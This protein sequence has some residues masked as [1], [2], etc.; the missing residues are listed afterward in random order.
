MELM[1][2]IREI[3]KATS[4]KRIRVIEEP[5]ES[6]PG[7]ADFT[8]RPVFSVFDY[9][10]IVPPIELDNSSVCLMAGYNFELLNENGIENHYLGL[11]T[12][13]GEL[14]TAKEAV[15]RKIAPVT[16]RLQFVNRL[17][18]EFADGEWSYQMFENPPK[19]NY[20]LPMEFISRNS[21]PE[22]SSIWGRIKEGSLTLKELG[23]PSD[24][25]P[26]YEVPGE[27]KPILDYSTK[28][29]PEDRYLNLEEAQEVL[30]I[31]QGRFSE[32]N[33]KTRDASNLMTDYAQSLEFKREDG[34]VE[35]ITL[36]VD[37]FPIDKLGD[38]VCSW[39]ED[40]ISWNGLGISKQRI[41]D[42]VKS[43]N[44]EWYADIQ[45]CKKRAREE[46]HASFKD[47]LDKSIEYNSPSEKFFT[48]TNR[49]FRTATN[50][51]VNEKVYDVYPQRNES[52][53]DSLERAVEEFE[54]INRK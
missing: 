34:K 24:F 32:I 27:L 29:E 25:K 9:G 19:N 6:S 54:G 44:E 39:H 35:Y 1:K 53:T 13:E 45:E 42:K 7:L 16:M 37:G 41:R 33:R 11:V 31:D 20:V 46:G 14:I 4:V 22:N 40:R 21:L 48:A 50:K 3:K 28:F 51:W 26:G 47:L 10:T 12:N 2:Y 36:E 15:R 38:A 49:L 5:T 17:M 23:L 52:L 30:R 18:P 43:L 8:Y